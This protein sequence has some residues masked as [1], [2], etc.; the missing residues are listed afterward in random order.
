MKHFYEM[1]LMIYIFSCSFIIIL[2][3]DEGE[4]GGMEEQTGF[5]PLVAL[6]LARC[7]F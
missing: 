2:F 3:R 1:K 6:F 5:F 7:L 4:G